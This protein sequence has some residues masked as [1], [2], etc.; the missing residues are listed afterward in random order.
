MNRNLILAGLAVLALT[1]CL[2]GIMLGGIAVILLT[3]SDDA[4]P[5]PAVCAPDEK[6]L[7]ELEDMKTSGDVIKEK[8]T[9]LRDRTE[10][11]FERVDTLAGDTT[12]PPGPRGIYESL[13]PLYVDKVDSFFRTAGARSLLAPSVSKDLSLVFGQPIFISLDT[14]TVPYKF[15]D[16]YHYLLV[17]ITILDDLYELQ[18]D[19]IWDSLEGQTR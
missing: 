12:A 5:A 2:I 16:N 17:K 4:P 3:R 10:E 13:P 14:I 7:A 6:L 18:F 11:L 1:S 9:A 8:M 15:S 19:V